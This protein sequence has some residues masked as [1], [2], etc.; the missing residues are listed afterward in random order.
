MMTIVFVRYYRNTERSYTISEGGWVKA[1]LEGE[2]VGV[3][4]V[5]RSHDNLPLAVL[6]ANINLAPAYD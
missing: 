4:G 2:G 6:P 3:K 1:K 5:R